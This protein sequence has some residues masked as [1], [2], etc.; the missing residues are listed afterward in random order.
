MIFKV[1]PFAWDG[2]F[3]FWVPFGSYGPW[4]VA[5][6]Y[7]LLRAIRQQAADEHDDEPVQV[8]SAL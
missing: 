6:V 2:L 1:G 4:I 8:A 3:P 5:L 7:C